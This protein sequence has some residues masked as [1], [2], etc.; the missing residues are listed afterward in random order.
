MSVFI[1]RFTQDPGN[2][3]LLNIESVNILDLNPPGA[4][5][6]VGSGTV[7]LVGEFENGLFASQPGGTVEVFSAND[8]AS[9][10]GTLGYTYNGQVGQNPCARQRFADGAPAAEFWNGNAFVQLNGKQFSRLLLCRVDTSVGSVAFQRLPYLTGAQAFRY[11]LVTGQILQ[12]DVGAG[13]LSA[14]FTGTPATV[15]GSAAAF[16][17]ITAGATVTLQYDAQAA[18]Q[19]TFLAGDTTI[20]NVVA[21][22]NQY[23]GFT[24][25]A[26]NGGQLQLTGLI[27]G[28]A[29]Q[30]QVVS[31]STGTLTNL[32]LTA[33]TTLG[34]GNVQNIAGVQVSE[35]NTIV[36]AAIANTQVVSDPNGALRLVN[37]SGVVGSF[38]VIGAATTANAL[39]FLPGQ[40]A[41]DNGEPILVSG[42]GTYALGTTGT[43]TVQLD[44]SLP[45][46]IVSVTSAQ[47]LTQT[48]AD[49]NTAFTAAGQGAPCFSDGTTRFYIVGKTTSGTISVVSASAPAVLTELGLTVGT[50]T[51]T[52][53]IFG[54]LTAGTVVSTAATGGT[55]FVTMQD[56][57]FESTGVSVAGIPQVTASS[58]SVKVRFA[59][60]DNSGVGVNAGSVTF[61]QTQSPIGAFSVLNAQPLTNALTEAQI[62]AQYAIAI[63]STVNTSSVA[64]QANLIWSAR[65]SNTV[66]S[67][68][69]LNALTASASGCLGRLAIVR[70]P[71]NFPENLAL[72][73]TSLQGAFANQENTAG[74]VVYCYPQANTFVPIIGLVG[75]QG[76]T[77][78]TASGNVDV[79]ADGFLASICSQLNPEEDPGQL[80]SFTGGI[81]GLESGANIQSAN[82]GVGFQMTDY[83]A[84]KAAGICALRMDNGQAIFQ[85]GV[86]CVNPL[87]Y[88]NL[89][90][91]NRRRMADFIQD[92]IAISMK[93]FGKKLQTKKRRKAILTEIRNFL[94]ALAGGGPGAANGNPNN[95]DSQRIDSYGI[96]ASQNTPD[97]EGIG[98]YRIV[99]AVR[100]LSTFK[101]IVL[102]TTIGPTVVVADISPQAAAA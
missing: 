92:S 46:V 76:G 49:F 69:R 19:T 30:V 88:S 26:N 8:V 17:S 98:L 6:G 3:V 32:G 71:M 53:P 13:P 37:T 82:G 51:G 57:D 55:K 23:A 78:F 47:T 96:D 70:S 62:D 99:I 87:I 84:F 41:T 33:G 61:L 31:G 89:T 7:L 79:G 63:Q 25:A 45:P 44:A 83:Q 18:F 42:S 77:G 86:C 34:S 2:T 15:T 94:N 27:G 48:V 11:A 80:T 24:F 14:T 75:V 36:S 60:D 102:Q 21:R 54:K 101:A 50:T 4:I 35:I 95:E 66:R 73:Q 9:S 85:S 97:T 38:I 1:R 39:G 72:S 16:G 65:Q 68:L 58:Y 12:V 56:V 52:A 93:A 81:N 67:Q 28:L 10:Y 20:A 43:V 29:G 40:E 74:R 5:A 100:M 64:A 91:I 90:D 59:L 22:I